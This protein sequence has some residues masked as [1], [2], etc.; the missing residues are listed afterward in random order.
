MKIKELENLELRERI[1]KQISYELFI[2]ARDIFY[3]SKEFKEWQNE[4]KIKAWFNGY[5]DNKFLN[6]IKE[7]QMELLDKE[8]SDALEKENVE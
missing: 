6:E 2:K 8:V 3:N 7:I 5:V 4:H 1:M